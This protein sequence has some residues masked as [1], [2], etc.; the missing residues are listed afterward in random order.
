MQQRR[1][2]TW[3]CALF[4][5]AG[6]FGNQK[7]LLYNPAALNR[8]VVLE[9]KDK[10][11]IRNLPSLL[12]GFHIAPYQGVPEWRRSYLYSYFRGTNHV[13]EILKANPDA[14]IVFAHELVEMLRG[15]R[16][17]VIIGGIASRINT[18]STACTLGAHVL[19]PKS[20]MV[21]SLK[22]LAGKRMG[23]DLPAHPY[24]ITNRIFLAQH[25]D[26]G[27]KVVS[28]KSVR[29]LNLDSDVDAVLGLVSFNSRVS[30]LHSFE[31]ELE[32]PHA[33]LRQV[34]SIDYELP[35]RPVFAQ[36]VLGAA[37]IAQVT[38]ALSKLYS[39]SSGPTDLIFTPVDDGTSTRVIQLIRSAL[40]HNP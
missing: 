6:A 17:L 8:L 12:P 30:P 28:T 3:A 27:L 38:Q 15:G 23:A 37:G 20:S 29:S 36:R 40:A 11:L 39:G 7:T 35:C 5:S 22:N 16:D 18:D 9:P 2:W 19:V 31:K 21:T 14:G 1:I 26:L 32:G 13:A 33:Y 24:N 4:M 25:A 10:A 34:A